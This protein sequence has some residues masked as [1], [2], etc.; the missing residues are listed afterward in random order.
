MYVH[1]ITQAVISE[2]GIEVQ[3]SMAMR[4]GQGTLSASA[5][6]VHTRKKA[7][8]EIMLQECVSTA[9][10]GAFTLSPEDYLSEWE[11]TGKPATP[12]Q[13]TVLPQKRADTWEGA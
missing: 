8:K 4:K 13:P 3:N 2:G 12:R 6:N 11:D 7:N 1:R 9:R 5:N 10:S